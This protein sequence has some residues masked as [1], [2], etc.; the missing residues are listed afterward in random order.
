MQGSLS[1]FGAKRTSRRS[2]RLLDSQ[3]RFAKRATKA[4][5]NSGAPEEIR[6]PDPQIRRLA[7]SVEPK[8]D[9][10][11]SDASHPL[12]D[13]RVKPPFANRKRTLVAPRTKAE[14]AAPRV[15]AITIRIPAKDNPGTTARGECRG[16][17][18]AHTC[19][20][21][22]WCPACRQSA[23]CPACV[24]CLGHG[25]KCGRRLPPGPL[26]AKR[27]PTAPKG[28]LARGDKRAC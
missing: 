11:K 5:L 8:Q 20:K 1:A 9:F 15:H 10:C 14:H 19:S 22:G 26:N 7:A 16:R 17:S 27:S 21:H 18:F 13:Q 6:T 12:S 2:N 25:D 4:T 24:R 3:T 28:L 23:S